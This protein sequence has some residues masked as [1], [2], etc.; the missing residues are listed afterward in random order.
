VDA[1]LGALLALKTGH[2]C[3]R[4]AALTAVVGIGASPAGFWLAHRVPQRPLLLA[5]A[6]VTGL[7]AVAMACKAIAA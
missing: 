6:C 4:A 5:F 2:V 1:R 7:V 3:Y